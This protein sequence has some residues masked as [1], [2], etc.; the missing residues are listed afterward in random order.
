MIENDQLP[1][2]YK[3]II[4][5]EIE[6]FK[7]RRSI[8]VKNTIPDTPQIPIEN[9]KLWLRIP[10]VVCVFV[11]MLGS[12]KLS[13]ETND[14]LTAGIYRFFSG[15]AV[16][17]FSEFEAPYIDVRGDGVLALFDKNQCYRALAA[18]V[19]FKT[20]SKEEFIPRV[21]EKTSVEIGCHIGID[22]K[23]VLVRKIGFKRYRGRSDRQNEVWAGKPVNM[24]SKLASLTKDNELFASDR[25]YKKITDERVRYTCGCP[26]G[27]KEPLW[28]EINLCEDGRFDFD[29][30]HV[31]INIWCKKHGKE[32]CEA[33]LELDKE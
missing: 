18:A 4:N 32:Y 5:N 15:T 1:E 17:L 29:T 25:Y 3:N 9:P 7:K 2:K 6:C 10:D 13:A 30:A 11:D 8:T 31:L 33:I 27:A 26:T 23:T 14:N 24:A 20:F 22:C 28:K 21:K 12:S 19:T 16:R